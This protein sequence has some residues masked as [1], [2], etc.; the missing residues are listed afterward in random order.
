MV[1]G[2]IHLYQVLFLLRKLLIIIQLIVQY[3]LLSQYYLLIVQLFYMVT[4]HGNKLLYL[5]FM[6]H[7]QDQNLMLLKDRLF[8][9]L[10]QLNNQQ[11][12]LILIWVN[13]ILLILQILLIYKMLLVRIMQ[14][15]MLIFYRRITVYYNP[16]L[17]LIM[18]KPK[19]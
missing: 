1:N 14:M 16:L 18:D 5:I 4:V 17:M 9:L 13:I 19:Y 8:I 2:I 7:N 11:F 12:R 6:F 3:N 15:D 10:F